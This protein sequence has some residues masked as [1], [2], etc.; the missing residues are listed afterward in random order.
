MN[1][2]WRCNYTRV[3][4]G[5]FPNFGRAAPAQLRCVAATII[6]LMWWNFYLSSPR[7]QFVSRCIRD[8]LMIFLGV[9]IF[10]CAE[11]NFGPDYLE[12]ILVQNTKEATQRVVPRLHRRPR[13]QLRQGWSHLDAHLLEA[14]RHYK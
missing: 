4:C 7:L 11:G 10:V 13:L 6:L 12:L 5:C 14:R 2:S 1:E 8:E 9:K 3:L